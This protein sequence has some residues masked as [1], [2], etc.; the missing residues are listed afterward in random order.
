MGAGEKGCDN[1]PK[2]EKDLIKV[3]TYCTALE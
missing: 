3:G 2:K 1:K